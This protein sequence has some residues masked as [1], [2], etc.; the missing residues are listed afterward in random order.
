MHDPG[1]RHPD[2]RQGDEQLALVRRLLLA[3][4]VFGMLG[5]TLDLF[6]LEHTE[7]ATQ[8]IPFGVLAAGLASAAAVAVRPTR[9]VLRVFQAVMTLAVAAGLL[10]LWL[11][12]RGNVE[13]ELESDPSAHG[14]ALFWLAVRGATPA[15]A[16][17][18]LAQ[19]G[20]IGLLFTFRHPGLRRSR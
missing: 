1:V 13:F 10:G 18:A 4:A 3:L 9:A 20:L 8:W 17:A 14:L 15:L 19:V 6:L 7:S 12:Y 5:L 16:P 2:V 11:H